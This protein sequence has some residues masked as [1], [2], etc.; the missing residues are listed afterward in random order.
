MVG[1]I[2]GLFYFHPQARVKRGREKWLM[3]SG[4]EKREGK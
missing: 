3:R 2:I 1:K 4:R